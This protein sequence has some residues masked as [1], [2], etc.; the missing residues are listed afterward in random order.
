M[1]CFGG[2]IE[3]DVHATMI[4]G[5]V[6]TADHGQRHSRGVKG[7][8]SRVVDAH[9]HHDHSVR[10]PLAA[11]LAHLVG[12]GGCVR[13]HHQVVAAFPGGFRGAGDE[14]HDRSAEP[15]LDAGEGQGNDPAAPAGQAAGDRVGAE[16]QLHHGPLDPLA[17]RGGD[18]PGVVDGVGHRAQR[19]VG[20]GGDILHGGHFASF[21]IDDIY[22]SDLIRY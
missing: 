1:A 12:L 16:V 15:V 20:A 8:H 5:I 11:H 4:A 17:G 7:A 22:T 14:L 10:E 13:P 2:G 18:G 19:D 6:G 9:L 3:I 21:V